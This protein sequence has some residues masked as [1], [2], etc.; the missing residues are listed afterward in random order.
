MRVEG[1]VESKFESV[2]ATSVPLTKG[3]GL[4]CLAEAEGRLRLLAPLKALDCVE[5]FG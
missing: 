1:R 5:A 2:I 3:F 4:F